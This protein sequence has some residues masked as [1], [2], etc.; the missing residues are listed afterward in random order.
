MYEYILLVNYTDLSLRSYKI[1]PQYMK[2]ERR[3]RI[4][5]FFL[6]YFT[7]RARKGLV[8]Q[9]HKWGIVGETGYKFDSYS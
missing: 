1:M 7:Y 6:F 9:R 2:N 5:I 3:I 4:C 8:A